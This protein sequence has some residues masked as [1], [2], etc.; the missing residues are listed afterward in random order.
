MTTTTQEI[1]R[2]ETKALYRAT[3]ALVPAAERGEFKAHIDYFIA[4]AAQ[5]TRGPLYLEA[6]R[7]CADQ[8][9]IELGKKETKIPSESWD[10]GMFLTGGH[11]FHDYSAARRFL[12]RYYPAAADRYTDSAH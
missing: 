4:Q 8:V 1:T 7:I 10:H 6:A 11:T 9:A 2:E 3:I 12:R 5:Y